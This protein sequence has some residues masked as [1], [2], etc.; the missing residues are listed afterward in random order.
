VAERLAEINEQEREIQVLSFNAASFES[1]VKLTDDK[2]K[3]FYEKNTVLFELPELVKIEYLL[4]NSDNL[5]QQIAV[6]DEEVS[7]FYSQNKD[8]F[9]TQPEI[10]ASHILVKL[11]KNADD[12]AKKSCEIKGG[13]IVG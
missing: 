7:A 10:R 6:N 4:L 12:A 11:D 3:A 2:L 13:W 5:S 1:Q 8:S 9:S